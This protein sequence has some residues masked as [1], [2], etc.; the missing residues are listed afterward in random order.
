VRSL[1][2]AAPLALLLGACATIPTGPSMMV[3]PGSGRSFEQFQGDDALCRQWA[4]QQTG[5]TAQKAA[6]DSMVTSA[7]VGTLIGA[8]AG[9]AIG[10]VA[11]NPA[12]GA[13]AGAGVGLLGGTAA[14]AG[15]GDTS[16]HAVQR[17]YDVA[18]MQCMYAKGHQIPVSRG[19]V[20]YSSTRP[21]PPPATPPAIS[22][23]PA[24][25][26]PPAATT[27]PNIPP[28]PAGVPPPPPPGVKG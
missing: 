5:I 26:A 25:S 19:A 10:A 4:M 22:A 12:M 27:P 2:L 18:F 9:A 8:A 14:G 16:A 17:R 21:T 13:A 7:A 11:G 28:P 6:G 24:G 23:P 1:A 3:L 20:P 15:Y